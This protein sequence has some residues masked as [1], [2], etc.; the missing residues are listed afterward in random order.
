M[1]SSSRIRN[2]TTTEFEYDKDGRLTSEHHT[3]D[4]DTTTA[5]YTWTYEYDAS[6]RL[7]Q[8]SIG[9]MVCTMEY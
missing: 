5:D 7:L 2:R 4:S 1:P 8:R 6:G 9:E 3:E